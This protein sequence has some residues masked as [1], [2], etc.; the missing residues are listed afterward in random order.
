MAR[1][2][3]IVISKR[4]L[5]FPRVE[6][7]SVATEVSLLGESLERLSC[8]SLARSLGDLLVACEVASSHLRFRMSQL[9]SFW[10]SK[11]TYCA[12]AARRSMV[13]KAFKMRE[14]V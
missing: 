7:L 9:I 13:E 3:R 8:P 4:N 10:K 2:R 12:K 6:Q 1:R 11:G 14:I 5:L